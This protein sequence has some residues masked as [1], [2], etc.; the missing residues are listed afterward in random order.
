MR[1]NYHNHT[2]RCGHAC[3]MEEDYIRKAI[4]EGIY[5]LGFSDHSPYPLRDGYVSYSRMGVDEIDDYCQT[6]LDLREK[7]KN[8]IDIKIGFETEYYPKYFG[9]LLDLYRPHPI[10]YIIYAGHFIGNEGDDDD[11][12]F[13]AFDKTA[14]KGRMKAYVDNTVTAMK[15][16]RY[17]IIAHPDMVN[18]VGDLDYYRQESARLI[19]AAKEYNIP[20]EINLYGMR[21]GRHYPSEEFWRIAGRMGATATLGFDSHHERHVADGNEIIKGLRLA[22]KF[23]VNVIDEVKLIDPRF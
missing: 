14:D 7:Y 13:C 2:Y 6:L 21:D 20:L 12:T 9:A 3:G 1:C 16:G 10:D 11:F 18:F 23:G 22:D 4:A 8:Y 17:S 15:T 19:R 5:T